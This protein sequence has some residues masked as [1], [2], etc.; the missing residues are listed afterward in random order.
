MKKYILKIALFCIFIC[1]LFGYGQSNVREAQYKQGDAA[2]WKFLNKKFGE[3]ARKHEWPPCLIS[4]V[5]AK[6]TIDSIGNVKGLVFS[7]LKRT[8]QIFRSM[9]ESTILA[10]NG[11]WAPRMVNNKVVESKP[12]ILPLIYEIEAGCNPQKISPGNL[13][14]TYK[15]VPNGLAT[16]L[17]YILDFED[18]VDSNTTQLNCILLRPLLIVSI[19]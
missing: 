1:P 7:E 12:F 3:E 11:S 17:L 2:L 5:F 16:S 4:A 9:L 10:T 8:P 15:P 14:P 18:N 6:F 19:N 13:E